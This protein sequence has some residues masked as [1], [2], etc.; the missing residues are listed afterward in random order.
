M[1]T[2]LMAASRVVGPLAAASNVNEFV[3]RAMNYLWAALAWGGGIA[4]A[5]GLLRWIS[6]GHSRDATEQTNDVWI[7]IY[8]AAAVAI[9]L[10]AGNY[11]Q[12][13]EF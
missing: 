9:G 8:G 5:V 12:F 2:I 1:R 7:I 6:H 3:N 13:P 11:F 10:V 4:V